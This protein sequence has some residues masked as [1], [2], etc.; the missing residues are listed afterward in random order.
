MLHI[1]WSFAPNWLLIC[2]GERLHVFRSKEIYWKKGTHWDKGMA[3]IK[4][5][6][7][8]IHRHWYGLLKMG[9]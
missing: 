4:V 2:I 6:G 1:A 9:D 5:I 8:V 7:Y 3:L